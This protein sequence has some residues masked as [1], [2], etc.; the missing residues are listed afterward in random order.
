MWNIVTDNPVLPHIVWQS[1]AMRVMWL[2]VV[3]MLWLRCT[4][5]LGSRFQRAALLL[6]IVWFMLPGSYSPAYWLGLAFMVP[7]GMTVAWSL[8][9]LHARWLQ[10]GVD[11]ARSHPTKPLGMQRAESGMLVLGLLLGWFLLADML[12][13][14]PFSGTVYA[15]GFSFWAVLIVLPIAVLPWLIW[16]S[17]IL[18]SHSRGVSPLALPLLVLTAFVFTRLPSG[19]VW[20]ALLDPWLWIVLHGMALHR[21][22]LAVRKKR[23][24]L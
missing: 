17:Q 14:L 9:W 4:S 8:T 24:P 20:D 22:L 12:A 15:W 13:W 7:S 2:V 3:C 19:N 18:I 16:G 10:S 1:Y 5:M 11:P 23:N 6:W 21:I